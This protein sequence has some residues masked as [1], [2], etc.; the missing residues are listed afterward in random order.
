VQN[1]L[2]PDFEMVKV[3]ASHHYMRVKFP[4][5]NIDHV[6]SN[7]DLNVKISDFVIGR[8]GSDI[9]GE[10]FTPIRTWVGKSEARFLKL[11]GGIQGR[12]IVDA[13]EEFDKQRVIRCDPLYRSKGRRYPTNERLT[14]NDNDGGGGGGGSGNVAST[15]GVLNLLVRRGM[16]Q[17]VA[18]NQTLKE[19]RDELVVENEELKRKISELERDITSLQRVVVGQSKTIEELENELEDLVKTEMTDDT[20]STQM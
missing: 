19:E 17:V 6:Y 3:N 1:V 5:T 11:S 18:E 16:D 8:F 14:D 12:I 13:A 2:P 9:I 7:L 15:A 20:P 10:I 4:T